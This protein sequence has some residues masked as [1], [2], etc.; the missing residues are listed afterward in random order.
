MVELWLGLG[1][2]FTLLDDRSTLG[3]G[4]EVLCFR[5]EVS[6]FFSSFSG[7][8]WSSRSPNSSTTLPTTPG[9][10]NSLRYSNSIFLKWLVAARY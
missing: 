2:A 7:R 5:D 3:W 8:S 10:V 1:M 9:G 4:G 6:S